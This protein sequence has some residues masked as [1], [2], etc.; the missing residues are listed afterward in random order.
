MKHNCMSFLSIQMRRLPDSIG[1]QE[2]GLSSFLGRRI[3]FRVGLG[4]SFIHVVYNCIAPNTKIL[5][6]SVFSLNSFLLFTQSWKPGSHKAQ[7]KDFS[8]C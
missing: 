2:V 6:Y 3:Q 8:M 5:L 4:H 1:E 7:K